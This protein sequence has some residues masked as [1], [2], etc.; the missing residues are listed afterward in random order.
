[1][2][3]LGCAKNLVDSE[4]MLGTLAGQGYEIVADPANTESKDELQ[5]KYERLQAQKAA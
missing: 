2:L 5:Q 3:S 1:M 4:I